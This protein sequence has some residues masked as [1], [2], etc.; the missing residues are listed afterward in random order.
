[1]EPEKWAKKQKAR[2]ELSEQ[3]AALADILEA[4]GIAA[5]LDSDI[6]AI[7]LV[8]GQTD[9]VESYRAIRFLPLVAQRDR[10]PMQNDLRY[11]QKHMPGGRYVRFMVVTAGARVPIGDDLRGAITTLNRNISRWAS[12]ARSKYG[13]EVL[14]RGTEFTIDESKTFH[15]HAN[16]LY[17]PSKVL[18][19]GKFSKFLSWSRQR[20][21]GHH[22]KDNGRLE[23]PQEAIKY[24]FKPLDVMSLA[25]DPAQIVWLYEQTKRLK[26]MQPMGAFK[27]FRSDL[28][29]TGEKVA[30]LRT[31]LGPRSM[32][33]R[34]KR[35]TPSAKKNKGTSET[36]VE[37]LILTETLPQFRNTPWAESCLLVQGFTQ[38]PTTPSGQAG[39]EEIQN[40]RDR[41]QAH[42]RRN[43]APD[44]QIAL[45]KARRLQ[46][47]LS[48]SHQ[49]VLILRDFVGLPHRDP[50][51]MSHGDSSPQLPDLCTEGL[52]Q[53]E[54]HRNAE[55]M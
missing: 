9:K 25:N 12:D 50:N 10:Q 24:P 33:V 42:W 52:E 37:N 5:R 15:V 13:I 45:E 39:L 32:R 28:A 16:V 38:N 26:M 31:S 43:Q 18:S 55:G 17:R 8:T 14:F 11:Y 54:M 36:L 21:G 19:R 2:Q 40:F 23:K 46:Q 27:E 35:R 1:M 4:Q 51:G 22:I 7:G 48:P 29:D 6:T 41:A 47:G 20:L 3:T 53:H 44:P 49:N 34:K 30:A